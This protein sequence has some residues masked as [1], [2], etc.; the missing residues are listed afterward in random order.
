MRLAAGLKQRHVAAHFDIDKASVSA[1]ETAKST[2]DRRKL[3]QLDELYGVGGELLA[4]F[5]FSPLDTDDLGILRDRVARLERADA[6]KTSQ[7]A[8]LLKFVE[9]AKTHLPPDDSM[10]GNGEVGDP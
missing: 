3:A 4:M 2:P 5:G 8:S 1:W 7:I 10:P 6:Q 9:W